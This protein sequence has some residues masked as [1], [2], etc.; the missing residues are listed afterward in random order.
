VLAGSGLFLLLWIVL[1]ITGFVDALLSD[2]TRIRVMPKAVWLVL[3]LLFSVF[4]V[5]AWYFFG[6]PRRGDP[7]NTQRGTGAGSALFRWAS[8]Q[9]D[10][11][12]RPARPRRS[13]DSG[14]SDSSGWQ[15]GGAG[16]ARRSGP[17]APDDDPE[18]LRQLGRKRPEDPGPADPK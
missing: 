7:A 4:A 3:I 8:E 1:W 6:R 12:D 16:G 14:T 5:I 17:V 15:L 10:R 11:T 9:A 2:A 13:S 18:F